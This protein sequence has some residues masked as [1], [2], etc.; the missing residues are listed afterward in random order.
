MSAAWQFTY[1]GAGNERSTIDPLGYVTAMQYDLGNDPIQ[2]VIDPNPSGQSGHL[3]LTQSTCY[4]SD[5]NAVDTTNANGQTTQFTYDAL[6]RLTKTTYS[7]ATTPDVALYYGDAGNRAYMTDG[8]GPSGAAWA[9]SYDLSGRLLSAQD[10]TGA[11]V[12]YGYDA[13]GDK[14][15]LTSLTYPSGHGLTFAYNQDNQLTAIASPS[16]ALFGTGTAPAT[17]S[18]QYTYDL[19][20]RVTALSYPMALG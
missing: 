2:Q 11:K 1:D 17:T 13:S 20:G 8:T 7:S 10:P 4:D 6:D 14:G 16:N 15:L 18:F 5:G 12:S 3:A 9:Y 19:A